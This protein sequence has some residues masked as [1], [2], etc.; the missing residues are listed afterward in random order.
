MK[1][2]VM[3]NKLLKEPALRMTPMP[4]DTISENYVSAGWLLAQMDLGGGKFSF[5]SVK[6]RTVTVGL[7]AMA[8]HKPVFVGDDVSIY[9]DVARV[10]RSSLSV[11]VEAWSRRRDTLE[12]VKVTQ[13]LFSFVHI[14]DDKSSQEI[15]DKPE[16]TAP[17]SV[18]ETPDPYH[19][20]KDK[21]I[22]PDLLTPKEMDD[23]LYN[24]RRLSIR[25]IPMPRDTNYLGDIFGGWI[26]AQMDMAALKE[27]LR[28]A[29]KRVV[30]IGV[31]SMSFHKPVYVG[32]EVSFTT[33]VI[34]SGF[35]S[36]TVKVESYVLRG[37]S[38]NYMKVTEGLFTYVAID[39]NRKP[40]AVK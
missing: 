38:Q 37:N 35:S 25:T 27:A 29:Q 28:F 26:L 40:V 6:G 33:K 7:D 3:H 34:R 36:V 22:L 30:T 12:T 21:N 39:E 23:I 13:G 20:D 19:V 1:A 18:L 14:G 9:A 5:A 11:H 10:G 16:V 32:D 15:A 17:K 2:P 31:E 4:A 24:E 8:F